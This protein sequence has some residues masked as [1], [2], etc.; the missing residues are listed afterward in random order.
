MRGASALGPAEH[1][2]QSASSAAGCRGD[3]LQLPVTSKLLPHD[4][5]DAMGEDMCHAR[6]RPCSTPA[7]VEGTAAI[8]A[9]RSHLS[10]KQEIDPMQADRRSVPTWWTPPLAKHL[11]SPETYRHVS[12]M[13]HLGGCVPRATV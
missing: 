12:G 11:P 5:H 6:E 13:Q 2:L 10:A 1:W 8:E 9:L 3:L 7:R 4:A